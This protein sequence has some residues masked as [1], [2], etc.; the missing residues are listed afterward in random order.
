MSPLVVHALVSLTV[1]LLDLVGRHELADDD[2]RMVE[3]RRRQA[4]RIRDRLERKR[5]KARRDRELEEERERVRWRASETPVPGPGDR[6]TPD[7]V[8]GRDEWGDDD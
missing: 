4:A 7:V 1:A 8:R 3:A 2:P 5:A 6:A